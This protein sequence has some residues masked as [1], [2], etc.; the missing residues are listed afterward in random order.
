MIVPSIKGK[1]GGDGDGRRSGD[2]GDMDG[3][4]S[5]GNV[6]S[7][8]VEA[9]LLA[10]GSQHLRQS[11]RTGDNDLPVSSGPPVQH[12]DRLYGLVRQQQ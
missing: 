4:T 3:T 1:K 2:D 7:E 9:T 5:S 6:N 8:R 10:V 11:R 12:A